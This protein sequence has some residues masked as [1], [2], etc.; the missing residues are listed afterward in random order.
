MNTNDDQK[1][2]MGLASLA[3]MAFEGA[4]FGPL[5]S[6]LL[7]RAAHN[8]TDANALMDLSTVLHL[9]GQREC[10]LFVQALALEIQQVYRLRGSGDSV[11]IRLL[12]LVSPGDLTENNA[13][14]FLVE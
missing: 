2:L 13:L 12:A 5:R 3:K 4:D 7:D 6:R 8:E 9:M 11:G 14:E 1:P 10:A